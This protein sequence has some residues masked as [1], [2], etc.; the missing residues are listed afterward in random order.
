V[1]EQDFVP[2]IRE[3]PD[4]DTPR[5]VC[6]D[7][8]EETGQAGRAEFIRT[9]ITLARASPKDRRRR[10][11][12]KR[13]EELLAAHE[14]E[15]AAALLDR[16]NKVRFRRGFVERITLTVA[17]FL[18]CAEQLFALAP[19]REAV[20]VKTGPGLDQLAACPHLARLALIDFRDSAFPGED[21][22]QFV[23]S[24]PHL[25]GLRAFVLRLR[26]VGDAVIQGLVEAKQP[27]ALETLDLYDAGLSIPALEAL[28]GWPGAARLRTLILGG[29]NLG[30][31]AAFHLAQSPHLSGLR[32]LHLAH[33]AL[34]DSDAEALAASPHLGGLEWL[35]VRY[36]AITDEAA[37][38]LHARFGDRV[39]I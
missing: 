19:I 30:E 7:W 15:W 8:F 33:A 25:G 38:R 1:T 5:L 17:D 12:G 21:M 4:D 6:A 39:Y 20:F 16:V 11:L 9:Q 31:G 28:A 24:S 23:T 3:Q 35:D 37:D 2:A 32:V 27:P 10:R 22:V 18:D 13:E 26:G 36:N 14:E 34:E 29:S